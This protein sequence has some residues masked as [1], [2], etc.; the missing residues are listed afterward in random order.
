[1][2]V[3]TLLALLTTALSLPIPQKWSIPNTTALFSVG[4]PV[5]PTPTGTGSD[6]PLGKTTD[7]YDLSNGPPNSIDELTRG[8]SFLPPIAVANP[9]IEAAK[10]TIA[11]PHPT[12]VPTRLGT[13]VPH[14]LVTPAPELAPPLSIAPP[15]IIDLPLTVFP[16]HLHEG[17]DWDWDG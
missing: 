8:G 16:P 13:L 1:M 17:H 6:G 5:D 2:R 10:P 4:K 11:R 9:M 15:V 7:P 14:V 3:S 12:V